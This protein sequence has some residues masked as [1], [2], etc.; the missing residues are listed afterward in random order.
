M[1]ESGELT[2]EESAVVFNSMFDRLWPKLL[3]QQIDL[4]GLPSVVS[5]NAITNT[6]V[7]V[8]VCTE[9]GACCAAFVRVPLEPGSAVRDEDVWNV[10]KN[11]G[12]SDIVVDRF[13]KRRKGDFAC[14]QLEGELG[15]KVTCGVYENRP[16]TCRTF[17]AGSD[18]CHAIRRAYGLEPFLSLEEMSA[19]LNILNE[20]D[21]SVA[22]RG[23]VI[24]SVRFVSADD[25][26]LVRI[27]ADMSDGSEAVIHEFDPK[28]ETWYRSQFEGRTLRDAGGIVSSAGK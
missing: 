2:E 18:R 5:S 28:K 27:E 8:P 3:P 19:V 17:E 23:P 24:N 14:S 20:R 12:G 25:V 7:P 13:I 21:T 15:V 9:C 11:V 4:E 22:G 26:G 6:D 1:Y 16:K 10:E